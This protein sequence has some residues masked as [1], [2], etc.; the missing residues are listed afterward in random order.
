M[1]LRAALSNTPCRTRF[2]MVRF[3]NVLGSS[4]SVVPLFRSQIKSGGPITVTHPEVIRFFMTVEEAAQLVLQ[5]SALGEDKGGDVFVLEMGAPV[6]I[7]DLAKRMIRLAGHEVKDS[8][9]PFGD[10][11]IQLTGLRSGEKLYEE[12]LLGDNVTGTGHPMIMRAEE[13]SLSIEEIKQLMVELDRACSTYNCKMVQ[14]ILTQA[15]PGFN[16][17]KGVLDVVWERQQIVL[18]AARRSAKVQVLYPEKEVS[19]H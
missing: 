3:G 15:V 11:E 18:A 2:C 13:E 17:E 19:T 10:I 16:P 7:I 6:K 1:W 8:E 5:A 4:G 9:H 14:A 12:L